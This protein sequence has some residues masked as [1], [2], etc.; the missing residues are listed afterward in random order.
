MSAAAYLVGGLRCSR[1][2]ALPDAAPPEQL[3]A[4]NAT[5][6]T[7]VPVARVVLDPDRARC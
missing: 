2:R 7:A 4:L 5:H 3:D 6:E 1:Q